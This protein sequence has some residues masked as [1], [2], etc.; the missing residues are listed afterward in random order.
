MAVWMSGPSRR[1]VDPSLDL[2]ALGAGPERL[3]ADL[4]WF[5]L[6]FES[7]VIRAPRVLSQPLNGEVFPCQALSGWARW[8]TPGRLLTLT[9][10]RTKP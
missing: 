9:A 8:P 10:E 2:A 1:F 3:P 6:L 7:L 4:E 5:G